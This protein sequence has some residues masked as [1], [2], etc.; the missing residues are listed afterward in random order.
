MTIFIV[1]LDWTLFI[2]FGFE[3]FHTTH[4]T[5]SFFVGTLLA[6]MKSDRMNFCSA[7]S[8]LFKFGLEWIESGFLRGQYF[9]FVDCSTTTCW[10]RVFGSVWSLPRIRCSDL[11]K[12]KEMCRLEIVS[13]DTWYL[14]WC[15]FTLKTTKIASNF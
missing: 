12:K 8:T 6:E 2:V 3:N 11:E 10:S 14:S 4:A 13:I 9:V 7:N 1:K 5:D 15:L